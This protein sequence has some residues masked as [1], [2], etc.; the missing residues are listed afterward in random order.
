MRIEVNSVDQFLEELEFEAKSGRVY[1]ELVRV[2]I[3]RVPENEEGYTF[4]YNLW[5][6][7][8]VDGGNQ[9]LE[10]GMHVGAERDG[11]LVAATEMQTKIQDR[12]AE[13]GLSCRGGKIE[14]Y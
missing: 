1:N 8:V 12:A 9:L 5:A 6:T 13:L 2:R 4:R 3:D 7:A 10:F 11:A 14:K